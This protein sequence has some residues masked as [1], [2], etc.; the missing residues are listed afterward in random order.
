MFCSHV[1]A[2]VISLLFLESECESDKSLSKII[3]FCM[4]TYTHALLPTHTPCPSPPPTHPA[5]F[6][7]GSTSPQT[8][9]LL[10]SG[11]RTAQRVSEGKTLFVVCSQVL[12]I[13]YHCNN[14][15]CVYCI[16]DKVSCKM[17][18][19]LRGPF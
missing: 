8:M 5:F 19:I 6:Q 10:P 1:P 11:R 9:K 17:Y 15:L 14:K 12:A 2:F 4:S 13:I 3:M 18:P 7:V 16:V